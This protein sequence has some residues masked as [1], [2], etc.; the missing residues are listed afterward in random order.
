MKA[1]KMFGEDGTLKV[2]AIGAHPDD[3]ELG[4]FG[5]LALFKLNG[6]QVYFLVLTHGDAVGDPKK[7]LWECRE[8]A[9]AIEADGL[10]FGE[11][12]D[13]MITDGF[14][15]VQVIERVLEK[16]RPDIVFTHTYNDRHQDHR[17]TG[18]ASLSA[19]RRVKNILLY[20]GP[21][22]ALDF[23]PQLFIDIEKTVEIKEKLP[24]LFTSQASKHYFSDDVILG[25]AKHRGYQCGLRFAEAFE[26][27][28]FMLD[29]TRI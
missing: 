27:R 21:A 13:T 8:A 2:L 7:R 25:L 24:S 23:T 11:L 28:R 19:C 4:C 14:E 1:E 20:E 26:V 22:T 29:L 3:I 15:T 9:K 18:Y 17:N 6:N 16:V 5:S 10:F 12:R